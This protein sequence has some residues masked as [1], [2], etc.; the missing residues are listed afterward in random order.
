MSGTKIP[1]GAQK[2]FKNLLIKLKRVRKKQRLVWKLLWDGPS[3]YSIFLTHNQVKSIH[4]QSFVDFFPK[5]LLGILIYNL[6]APP[7][8]FGS[9][10][11]EKCCFLSLLI[12]NHVSVVSLQKPRFPISPAFMTRNIVKNE[13]MTPWVKL[14]K[15]IYYMTIL[16]MWVR[17]TKNISHQGNTKVYFCWFF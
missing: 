12:L 6:L 5:K 8:S 10:L 17:L 2:Y 14:N 16:G 1:Y 3:S 9:C 15:A 4:H 13:F 11:G 7:A